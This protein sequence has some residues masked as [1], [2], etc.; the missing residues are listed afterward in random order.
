MLEL[1][2]AVRR[3]GDRHCA[4]W[5]WLPWHGYG[6]RQYSTSQGRLPG[7][8]YEQTSQSRQKS[9]LCVSCVPGY[10]RIV[11]VFLREP[12]SICTL[13]GQLPACELSDLPVLLEGAPGK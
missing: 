6:M 8:W 11:L 12:S 7:T 4:L 10:I 9:A 13:F 3:L 2:L 5:Y 1:A